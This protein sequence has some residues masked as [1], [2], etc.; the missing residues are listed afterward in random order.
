[1]SQSK[2][3][4]RR[5]CRWPSSA[6]MADQLAGFQISHPHTCIDALVRGCKKED[7]K[8]VDRAP[9]CANVC[10]CVAGRFGREWG[11]GAAGRRELTLLTGQPAGMEISHPRASIV[12]LVLVCRLKN[13]E[14]GDRAP[15]SRGRGR[16]PPLC[17]QPAREGVEDAE[18]L[19]AASSLGG[20]EGRGA[21]PAAS[22][23]KGGC[24]APPAVLG[25]TTTMEGEEGTSPARIYRG[26]SWRGWRWCPG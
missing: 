24:G 22:G 18:L 26:R 19:R 16:C 12:A 3:R 6:D 9:Q 23:E 2:N 25:A 17:F 20:K 1:M 13:S 10:L 11:S 21:R 4:C 5:K 8:V 15:A 14:I 7:R